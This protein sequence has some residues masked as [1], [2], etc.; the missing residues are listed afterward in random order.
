MST[1]RVLAIDRHL[2]LE[3]VEFLSAH[4]ELWPDIVRRVGFCRNTIEKA[5]ERAG[6]PDIPRRINANAKRVTV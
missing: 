4:D 5:C 6:R 3:D 1:P 2:Y